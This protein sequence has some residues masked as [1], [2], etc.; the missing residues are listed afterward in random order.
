MRL[1]VKCP[2]AVISRC[3]VAGLSLILLMQSTT[4]VFAQE[5]YPYELDTGREFALTGTALLLYGIGQLENHG[6]SGYTE[7][8]L[9]L[10]DR[11]DVLKFDRGATYR[12]DPAA[13]ET[14]DWLLYS[15]VIAPFS[16][17][18]TDEGK[19]EPWTIGTMYVE[20]QLLNLGAMFLIKNL[21]SRTRP[22]VYNDDPR[23]PLEAKLADDARRSFVS[24]HA[25]TVFAAATF[26][27]IVNQKLHPGSKANP[28]VWGVSY[29]AA[30]TTAILRVAAGKHYPTDVMA[31][32]AL[33][34]FVGWLVPHLHESGLN[35]ASEQPGAGYQVSIVSF[36][37]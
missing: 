29:A 27:S 2:V 22:F 36:S 17:L 25:S 12:W 4:Q 16:L 3:L 37:F 5:P 33:G 9:A 19:K 10:L 23:I 21:T 31:G 1:N 28:W 7:E 30:T 34:I 32:A 14:S 18:L 15:M 8:E 11:S 20:T 6:E 26:L 24:G 35:S 13:G